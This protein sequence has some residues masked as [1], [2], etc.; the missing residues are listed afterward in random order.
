MKVFSKSE[1]IKQ[2]KHG[3]WDH[4]IFIQ[5]EKHLRSESMRKIFYTK[6]Q[7]LKKF[8]E[9][10]TER[11]YLRR[12]KFSARYQIL[13]VSKKNEKLRLCVNY[14]QLN[15][16]TIKDRTSLSRIDETMDRLQGANEFTIF[17]LVEAY[18]RLRMKKEEE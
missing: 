9:K 1:D 17:D 4:E 5:E 10:N 8:L 7:T 11:K 2:P 13:F 12:S 16:I 18:Y 3:S 6:M 15:D 14:R